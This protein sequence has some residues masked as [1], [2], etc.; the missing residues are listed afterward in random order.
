MR[1][2]SLQLCSTLSGPMGRSPLGSPSMGFSRQ[3]YRSGLL[4]PPPRDP[5][6]PGTEPMFL[7]SAALA[8]MFF[9]TIWGPAGSVIKVSS[10]PQHLS[11]GF[12]GLWC[13]ERGELGLGNEN[14]P[15][16][17]REG[18][19]CWTSS[20]SRLTLS[21]SPLIPAACSLG[22]SG[23]AFTPISV[24]V[25]EPRVLSILSNRR[26]LIS[27]VGASATDAL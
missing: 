6:D 12:V 15:A 9:S 19:A 23:Y 1:A 7:A 20:G 16:D 26:L 11:L 5:P 4:C 2:K 10:L 25:W 24:Q 22:L 13:G 17:P 18:A 21:R 8:G 14:S 27:P 3:E